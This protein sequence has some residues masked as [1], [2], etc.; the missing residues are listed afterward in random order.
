MTK[1]LQKP[2][3]VDGV[4][5]L[6]E[7]TYKNFKIYKYT[8]YGLERYSI[9]IDGKLNGTYLYLKYAKAEVDK[10]V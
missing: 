1:R 9:L 7:T 3:W 10:M 2:I 8:R 5:C 4:R 6:T